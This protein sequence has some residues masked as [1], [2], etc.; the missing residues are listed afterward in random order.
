MCSLTTAVLTTYDDK[1]SVLDLPFLFTSREVAYAA[2][3]GELG[4]QL[5]AL[6]PKY[7]L[8][9]LG[10]QDNGLRNISNNIRPINEPKDLKGIKIRV[11]ESPT[12]VEMFKALGANPTPMNFGE[13]YTALAQGTVDAQ[14]NGASLVYT[15]KF[16][17]V[18]KYYSLTNHVYSLNMVLIS[19]KFYDSLPSDIQDILQDGAK[20]LL[21]LK[22]REME[23]NSDEKYI[24]LLIEKGMIV[25]DITP[26]NCKKFVEAVKPVYEMYAEK[27]GKE[28]IE[29]AQSYNK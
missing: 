3:D 6:L 21:E 17:E 8:M 11:M 19:K 5:E 10:F 9:S 25:N 27:I 28:I 2:V 29:L 20:Q 12:Y 16:Y 7:N 13:V 26:E 18:Q 14:E 1:F 22:Q 24:N 4:Q 15:S 23:S